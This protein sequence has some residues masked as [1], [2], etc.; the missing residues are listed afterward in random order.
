MNNIPKINTEYDYFDDGKIRESRLE[1]VLIK[2][3]IPFSEIDEDT[4]S[5]W[6]IEVAEHY[7]L[8]QEETDYF[9]KA[10]LL[11]SKTNIIFV[12]SKDGW[13]SLGFWAGRLDIDGSLKQL[14]NKQI[15][16]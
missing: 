1:R 16:E 13:F 7:R 6:K 11:E 5:D 3:I 12:R 15:N 2:S 14:L 8:Y 4:L 10:Y 9:I